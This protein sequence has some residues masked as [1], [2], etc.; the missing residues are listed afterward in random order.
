MLKLKRRQKKLIR[1]IAV[2]LLV[3]LVFALAAVG[4]KWWDTSRSKYT[5]DESANIAESVIKHNGREYVIKD[6]IE[7]LLIIGLDKFAEDTENESYRSNMQA[8]FVMLLVMDKEKESFTAVHINRD[9]VTELNVL[10]VGGQKIDTTTGQL[11]LSYAYGNGGKI[12]CRNTA[13]AVSLLLGN[14]HI[15]HYVSSTMDAIAVLNDLVGGVPVEILDDFTNIDETLIQGETITLNGEQALNY[16]RSRYNLEDSTNNRRM[17][18]QRQYLNSLYS[19]A[20]ERTEKDEEFIIK[21]VEETSEYLVSNS[22]RLQDILKRLSQ[23]EFTEIKYLE[24]ESKLVGEYI[25]FAPNQEALQELIID[26]FY[27]FKNNSN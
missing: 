1:I 27:E 9:T 19:K 11:A 7:T 13:D 21:A 2:A 10:G 17:E 8:D 12:S 14:I 4:L 5:D 26:L 16:V 6:N 23:Y 22:T 3:V 18:R 25:E 20:K 15:D 24:G